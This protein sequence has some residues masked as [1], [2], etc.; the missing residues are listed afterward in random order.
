MILRDGLSVVSGGCL[1][2]A[3]LS[4]AIARVLQS[5]ITSQSLVDPVAFGAALLL[6][7]IVS[8][9]AALPPAQ[10]AAAATGRGPRRE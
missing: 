9:A 5:L 3:A 6:L 4:F 8:V 2:G 10:R 1:A 7:L